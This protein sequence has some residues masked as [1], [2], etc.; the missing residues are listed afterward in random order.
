LRRCRHL[1][2]NSATTGIQF[3]TDEKGRKAGVLIDLKTHGQQPG[4]LQ[5]R[6]GYKLRIG[7]WRVIYDLHD[8]RRV[9]QVLEAGPR[10]GIY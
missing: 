6:D 1:R 3:V 5:G 9:M 8:D 2:E 4:K 10:G 7:N